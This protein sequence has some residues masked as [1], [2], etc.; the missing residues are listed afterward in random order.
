MTSALPD[1][2]D[3][4]K[5]A[6]ENPEELENLRQRLCDEL[7]QSAPQEY[8]RR[9]RGIQFQIDMERKRAKTPMAACLK[10]SEMMHDSFSQLRD[11]LNDVQEIRSGN[12]PKRE[13][14]EVKAVSPAATVLS[15]PAK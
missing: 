13:E 15:F 12:G 7:I 2:D 6:Q 3:L 5:L 11:A 9:L 14:V 8:R 1:F 10:I 4:V